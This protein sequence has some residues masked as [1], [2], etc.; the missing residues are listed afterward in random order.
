MRF[1]DV[2]NPKD[3]AGAATHTPNT[4]HPVALLFVHFLDNTLERIGMPETHAYNLACVFRKSRYILGHL[5][6]IIIH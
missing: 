2:A 5:A 3:D 6:F 4:K 1:Y